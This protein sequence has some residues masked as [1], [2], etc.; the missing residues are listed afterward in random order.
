MNKQKKNDAILLKNK[1]VEEIKTYLYLWAIMDKTG[2]TVEDIKKIKDQPGEPFF[3]WTTYGNQL[4]TSLK[5]SWGY[6]T[7]ISFL[8][9]LLL[10]TLNS[11]EPPR[12]M[13]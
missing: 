11:G 10:W 2:E 1:E 6:W 13:R 12:K 5:P 7:Q 4:N 3:P 9:Y 8:Y